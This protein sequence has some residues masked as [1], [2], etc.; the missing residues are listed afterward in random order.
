MSVGLRRRSLE[1]RAY[2]GL[3]GVRTTTNFSRLNHGHKSQVLDT[4]LE[5]HA[6][7]TGTSFRRPSVTISLCV[8]TGAMLSYD[9]TRSITKIML[10][11][12]STLENRWQNSDPVD[13]CITVTSCAANRVL[14]RRILPNPSTSLRPSHPSPEHA[15]GRWFQPDRSSHE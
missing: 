7:T 12:Q 4:F 14:Y 5:H 9:D 1:F 6:P 13:Q 15:D 2:F 11:C 10:Y 8:H 3:T